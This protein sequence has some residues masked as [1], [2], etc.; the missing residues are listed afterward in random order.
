M[1]NSWEDE[2]ET[3]MSL[4]TFYPSM[5]IKK[6]FYPIMEIKTV[7]ASHIEVPT[8][9]LPPQTLVVFLFPQMMLDILCNMTELTGS[10]AIKNPLGLLV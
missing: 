9:G 8:K 5:E 4:E 3:E 1:L 7:L 6:G 10:L 2:F